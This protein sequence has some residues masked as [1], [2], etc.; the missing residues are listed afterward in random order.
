MYGRALLK[1]K[2]MNQLALHSLGQI[3]HTEN[4]FLMLLKIRLLVFLL[5]VAM[6][7]SEFA[8]S[9]RIQTYAEYMRAKH[10]DKH[11][12]RRCQDDGWSD[13]PYCTATSMTTAAYSYTHNRCVCVCVFP[14]SMFLW[15]LRSVFS[16]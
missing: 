16:S 10:R 3:R 7:T 9:Y 14:Y 5:V 11:P 2:S 13:M 4:C 15:F 12:G 6:N 8:E 1:Q